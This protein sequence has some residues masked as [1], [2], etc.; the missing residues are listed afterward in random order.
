MGEMQIG[1][2]LEN[3]AIIAGILHRNRKEGYFGVFRYW[4]GEGR[5]KRSLYR[6]YFLSGSGLS[7]PGIPDGG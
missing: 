4:P 1:L 5:G 7:N 2:I 6:A 3:G